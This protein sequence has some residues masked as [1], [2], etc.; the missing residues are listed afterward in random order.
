[1]ALAYDSLVASTIKKYADRLTDNIFNDLV[2]TW[3]LMENGRVRFEDGGTYIVEPIIYDKGY[4]TS[5]SGWDTFTLS[6]ARAH[7]PF[8]AAEFAWKQYAA[9][10]AI[11]GIEQAKNSGESAMFNLVESKVMN[12]EESIK[13][14][15][16]TMFHADGTG[17]S[18]KDWNGLANLVDSAGTV[19]GIDRATYTWWQSYEEGTAGQLTLADMTTAYNTCKKGKDAPDIIIT[20]QT[21]HERFES[22]LVPQLRYSD[23]KA[24]GV[25]FTNIMFKG[26]PVYYDEACASGVMYFLNSKYMAL[27]GHKQNWFKMRPPTT[28]DD[29]D[30]F[31]QLTTLYGNLTVRNSA[32]HGKLTGRTA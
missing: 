31:Y 3:H 2:L 13:D 25:G 14:G 7:E 10:L 29:A 16:N 1:M 5:Y 23:D 4:V 24:A 19:G 28:P 26:A 11:S 17:N 30:G 6:T 18:G 22:L 8:T 15:L 20:T 21:L 9:L 12:L 27:V 32:R